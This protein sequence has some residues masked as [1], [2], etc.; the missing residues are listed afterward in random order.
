MKLPRLP[1]SFGRWQHYC[2]Q[3]LA[4]ELANKVRCNGLPKLGEP[5]VSEALD[6]FGYGID[7][8]DAILGRIPDSQNH[9]SISQRAAQIWQ[10]QDGP[11]AQRLRRS[12]CSTFRS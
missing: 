4:H 9:T 1:S 6:H 7:G 8:V 12:L 5:A 10:T 11:R 2:A 3:V